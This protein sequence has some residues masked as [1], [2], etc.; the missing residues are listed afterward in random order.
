MNCLLNRAAETGGLIEMIYIS[1]KGEL[2]QRKIK[3][4]EVSSDSISAFCLL[5]HQKRIFKRAN[6]LSI[7][8]VKNNYYR[9]A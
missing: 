6:I 3:V 9:G 7:G 1:E 8:P 4:F 2:S 5:R